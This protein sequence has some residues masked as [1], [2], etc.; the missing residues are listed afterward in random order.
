MVTLGR[1][2]LY[3]LWVVG[4]FTPQVEKVKQKARGLSL[5]IT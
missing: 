4:D 2:N 1:K 5:T 3:W